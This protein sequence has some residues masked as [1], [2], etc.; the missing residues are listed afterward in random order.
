MPVHLFVTQINKT[1]YF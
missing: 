1:G